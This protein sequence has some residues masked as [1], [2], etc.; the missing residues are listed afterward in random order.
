[1]FIVERRSL[2]LGPWTGSSWGLP[3]CSLKNPS[4]NFHPRRRWRNGDLRV[5][6]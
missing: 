3:C 5:M 2:R 4:R 6:Q 1:M